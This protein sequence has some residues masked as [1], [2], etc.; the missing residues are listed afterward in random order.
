MCNPTASSL[1]ITL[2]QLH[3]NYHIGLKITDDTR[4]LNNFQII[5]LIISV[6][7]LLIKINL[8]KSSIKKNL[9]CQRLNLYNF[10]QY[11]CNFF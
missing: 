5:F 8:K 11:F 7:F 1:T 10:F 6:N 2:F 9:T 3:S 4:N